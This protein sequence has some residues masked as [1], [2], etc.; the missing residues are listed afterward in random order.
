MINLNQVLQYL[1]INSNPI[2][3]EGI[4]A[5]AKNLNN[6]RICELIVYNC[7]ITVVGTKELAESLTNNYTIKSLQL[8]DNDITLNGAI[9]T[10]EAAITNGVCQK[11]EIKDRYKSDDKV[12]GMMT[13][14]QRRKR[15][16]VRSNVACITVI[17]IYNN[18]TYV[19]EGKRSND[20]CAI[21]TILTQDHHTD[22]ATGIQVQRLILICMMI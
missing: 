11:V 19:Q 13:I 9:V 1:D 18:N 21:A 4:A 14:L 3:D 10:L 6:S 16:A 8:E 20:V 22:T 15:Q 17:T 12:K 2:N 7:G 5:I